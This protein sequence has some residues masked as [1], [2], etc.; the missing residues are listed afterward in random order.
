[1]AALIPL[2]GVAAVLGIAGVTANQHA[3]QAERT[4][5][6]R[7]ASERPTRPWRPFMVSERGNCTEF[8][9]GRLVLVESRP[10][11]N[12]DVRTEYWDPV[13]NQYL[14]QTTTDVGQFYGHNEATQ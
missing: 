10:H 13:T 9:R 14:Q 5:N 11:W 7:E 12:G 8:T 4:M 2:M 1:M 3:Y 6:L